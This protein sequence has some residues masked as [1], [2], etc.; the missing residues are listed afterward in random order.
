MRMP[1]KKPIGANAPYRPKTMFL[2]GP[3]RYKLPTR[4][5]PA[6]Q[7]AAAPMACKDLKATKVAYVLAKPVAIAQA[8]NHAMPTTNTHPCPT[9]SDTRLKGN[10]MAAITNEKTDAGHV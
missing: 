5:I 9:R 10:S 8:V 3:G 7:K 2:R 1:E 4:V 6:G